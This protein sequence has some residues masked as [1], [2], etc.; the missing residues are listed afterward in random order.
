M[1]EA[2]VL[3]TLETERR[4]EA[5]RK[6][7]AM[8]SAPDPFTRVLVAYAS[9]HGSTAE[10]AQEVA[11]V[12]RRDGYDPDVRPVT[13]VRSLDEYAGVVLGG[14]LY[15]GR[16]H[17]DAVRF[18]R[19]HEEAFDTIPLAVFGMGP[20]TL[21]EKDV[22]SA[23][24]QLDRSL[25]KVPA[26]TPVAEAIFGGVVRPEELHFP[27]NRMP[28]TDARDS[29]AIDAWAAEVATAF[30]EAIRRAPVASR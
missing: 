20:L 7:P 14:G 26:V 21:E 12:L 6:E 23:R 28:A 10:V 17:R 25:H 4:S 30:T 19:R 27:F 8:T 9:K 18:L 24:A 3:A 5:R 15:M 2:Y 29:E 1:R 11:D 16:W 13:E 22:A